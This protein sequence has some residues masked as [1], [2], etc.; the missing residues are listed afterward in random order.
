MGMD[1]FASMPTRNNNQLTDERMKHFFLKLLCLF[2]AAG[3]SASAYAQSQIT[4]KGTV[5][6]VSGEKLPGAIIV[7]PGAKPGT[8]KNSVSSDVNGNFTLKCLA[9][10]QV[11]VHYIGYADFK[12]PVNGRTVLNIVLKPDA[13]S[14]LDE[15]VVI[16]YGSVKKADVTGSVTSVKMADVRDAPGVSIDHA[17]QGR[18]AGADILSV[19]GDPSSSTSIRIRGTRSITASNEPLIVVDDV[20]D[21]V[22]SLEDI[23]PSDIE[24]VTFLKDASSTAIYGA[25]GSNGVILITT[26]A[27]STTERPRIT[28]KADF[29][30]SQLPKRL[31]VMDATEFAV[32]RNMYALNQMTGLTPDQYK[33]WEGPT[34]PDPKSLGKG[35][36]W[37][38][39]ITRI[40]PHQ[41]YQLSLSGGN[42]K[43]HYFAS[44]GYL[45]HQGIIKASGMKRFSGRLNV[46]N[47]LFKWLKVT[48]KMMYTFRHS[49]VNKAVIGG[50]S[51][52]A[53]A[54][55][56]S[57]LMKI[58]DSFN[59][60]VY[61][62]SRINNPVAMVNKR[63]YYYESD[64]TSHTVALDSK[65]LR[66]IKLRSQ[67]TYTLYNIGYFRYD[68]STMPIKAPGEGGDAYRR[69]YRTRQLNSETTATFDRTWFKTHHL[70]AVVGFTGTAFRAENFTLS[71]SGYMEDA[72]KWNN[73]NGVQDKNSYSATTSLSRKRTMSVLARANY[74]YK[75][76][77]YLTVTGRY[78]GASNFAANRK[79]GFFPS[80]A[81][82]WNMAKEPWLKRVKQIDELSLKIGVGRTGNDAIPSYRSM[83]S[84]TTTTAGYVFG[85]I[86]PVAYYSSRLPSP[87]LTWE[88]TDQYNV[89]LTGAFFNRRLTVEAEAYYS[90]TTDLL[91]TVQTAQH[92]G[93][94]TRYANIG[95]TSNKGL[96]LTL[97]SRNIVKRRFS[98]TTDFTIS[99][100]KQ[101]VEDIGAEARIATYSS[102]GTASYMM[103][104]YVKG[105]PLNAMWGF[106]YAGVWHNQGE[107]DRNKMTRTYIAL[108]N[109]PKPGG[110]RYLD[111][112]HDGNMSEDDLVY[113]GNAD[114]WLYGGIQNNFRIGKFDVSM[115][116]TY[117]L[118][119]KIYNY[120]ELYMA[121]TPLTNQYRYM[122]KAWNAYTNADSDIPAA[123][124]TS[125]VTTPSSFMIHD[126]S[127]IRLKSMSLAYTLTFKNKKYL[128]DA[129]FAIS[130]D[131]LLLFSKYNG[132]DPDV[133]SEGSS[134]TLRRLD[135]G[136]YP[137]AR[138]VMFSVQLRY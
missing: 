66:Y 86:Q 87:Y 51:F 107:I 121:G 101:M 1:V 116:W 100:N 31:D 59:P 4:V 126:A 75:Q 20:M 68:P 94:T 32:Y 2:A 98:W 37:I 128:R 63:E 97:S 70:D 61:T 112:N 125:G 104:G 67:L 7:V 69:E 95:A 56:L 29:G 130:G 74:N 24:S 45:D 36:D 57:P 122:L 134:S 11:E 96:E 105:Y 27:G 48:Y 109:T 108:S 14:Q 114:P 12:E 84:L 35:T 65:V 8:V 50:T 43:R 132:F 79:W 91:L 52:N 135:L 40:A 64:Q 13:K 88:T 102:S 44:L 55:Y 133:S 19:D 41:N 123:G 62:N 18:I 39:A 25:R 54:L 90:K 110:A 47:Q 3:L 26:K 28:F 5:S 136:A 30:V 83:A 71:G 17:L 34:Y 89:A 129:R 82:K 99:H 6:D 81:A 106:V 42:Q 16:G 78:D 72:I 38:G 23:N 127:F 73:M 120:S 9:T 49:D 111:I 138:M 92:T 80:A 131:N 85:D 119:G 10:D 93:Y 76:K 115:Y 113:L 15:A 124:W 117:S 103:N 53:G 60:F 46:D 118:G 22:S 137:K 21:A 33:P 58:T 77:Y